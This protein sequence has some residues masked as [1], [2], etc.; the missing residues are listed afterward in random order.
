[1]ARQKNEIVVNI[2]V[3]L[4]IVAGGLML[5]RFNPWPVSH[6]WLNG[7][8][9]MLL[10]LGTEAMP[11]SL[12]RGG[13]TVSVAFGVLYAAIL[14]FGPSFA[15]WVAA[16]GTIRRRELTGDVPWH[17]LLFNR[18]QLALAAGAAAVVYVQLGGAPP[19]MPF[20]GRHLVALACSALTFF[21]IN[22]STVAVAISLSQ[23]VPFWNNWLLNFRWAAPHDLALMPLGGLIAVVFNSVGYLGVL[24]FFLPLLIARYSLQ[25]YNDLR[26]VYLS[27]ISALVRALEQKDPYTQGHS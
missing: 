17:K 5:L 25:R 4:V 2:Y 20:D 18:A 21:V 10:A 22:M 19:G 8:F 26:T 3:A 13:G 23:G 11:I 14:T 27:T 24:L 6:A 1:M 7:L 15:P 9:F 12:P 16:L